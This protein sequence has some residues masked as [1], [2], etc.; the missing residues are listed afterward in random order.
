[1]RRK[2]WKSLWRVDRLIIA[3]SLSAGETGLVGLL[4]LAE[5]NEYSV[6]TVLV[7]AVE[8]ETWEVVEPRLGCQGEMGLLEVVVVGKLEECSGMQASVGEGR[9]G[10]DVRFTT[11]QGDVAGLAGVREALAAR[12]VGTGELCLWCLSWAPLYTLAV[13]AVVVVEGAGV[14]TGRGRR[15]DGQTNS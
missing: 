4:L 6:S 2:G 3:G 15:E 9:M 1:M 8:P 10:K 5:W 14:R 7:R 13:S 12:D 11:S